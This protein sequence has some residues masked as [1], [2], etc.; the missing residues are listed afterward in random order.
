MPVAQ[1][2]KARPSNI[3][4]VMPTPAMPA[5]PPP[6]ITK[7]KPAFC[8]PYSFAPPCIL[9]A[10]VPG[11]WEIGAQILFARISGKVLW[12]RY[13]QYYWGW[14]GGDSDWLAA[15]F[16]DKLMLP[17]HK[18]LVDFKV[19]YQFR[20]NW[21]VRYSVIPIE[22]NG[23]GWP[24]SWSYFIFGN[25]LYFGG[26][27]VQSKWQHV[28]Q[29]VGLIYDAVRTC[30]SKLSIF[31]DWVHV[32]DRIDLNCTYCGYYTST[33][34]KSTDSM[35]V[36]LELQRCMVRT[37]NGGTFSC[38]LKGGGIFLDDVAGYDVEAGGRYS[39]ALNKA[40]RWGYIKGGYR[41]IGLDKTQADYILKNTIEGGFVEFGFIF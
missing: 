20:P 26:Q 4:K 34:S 1:K 28:Y 29:R 35:M 36:G 14:Y 27:P 5:C 23:G 3:S 25:Q 15:G 9:P 21:A 6:G 11:Q 10:P 31:A 22:L 32:D 13:S 18:V 24:D 37:S 41:A 7:V 17:A 33:F 38:D 8:P 40:G 12:P 39:I 16:T 30:S 2:A 19:R